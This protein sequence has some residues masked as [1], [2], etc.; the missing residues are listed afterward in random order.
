MLNNE[1]YIL[2]IEAFNFGNEY[3]HLLN[4]SCIYK[5]NISIHI[6]VK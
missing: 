1:K 3:K 4:V 6:N 5:D 2:E